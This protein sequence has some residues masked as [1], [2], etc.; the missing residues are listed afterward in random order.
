MTRLAASLSLSA[1][2]A[3]LLGAC[4]STPPAS[5][6]GAAPAAS[7][8]PFVAAPAPA[9]APAPSGA[10]PD[11]VAWVL[12]SAE[13]AAACHQA[14][15]LASRRIDEIAAGRPPG[16]WA[17]ALDVDETV[18]SN[19]D[20]EVDNETRGGAFDEGAW[21]RWVAKRSAPAL[22]GAVAFLEKVR[23]MGGRIALVTNR[24]EPM[25][26]DTAADLREQGVPFD[27]LLLRQSPDKGAKGPRWESVEQGTAAPGVPPTK[28]VLWVG[29]NI[30]D[31][32]GLDQT[33][34]AAGP[35]A[36]AAFGDRYIIVPNPMYGSW[37]PSSTPMAPT[38]PATAPV[39]APV[40]KP[41]PTPEPTP[42]N[43]NSGDDNSAPASEAGGGTLVHVDAVRV[44]LLKSLP[45]KLEATVVGNLSDG[46]TRLGDPAV[47][48][49]RRTFHVRLPATRDRGKMCTEALVPFER[50]FPVSISGLAS[51]TYTVE[52]GGK[53][54]TFT[55]EQDN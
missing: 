53:T 29:D 36:L 2:L 49:K 19:V 15:A 40:A 20:H 7:S 51:G 44:M 17:V 52:A 28:I 47:E 8:S 31:F 33:L 48:R 22:P 16:T 54:A 43:D 42:S 38:P 34:R 1:I 41:T 5:T 37:K 27:L 55:L 32:P 24:D 18:L 23:R 39:P 9:A 46:C 3:V 30:K 4:A 11:D 21:Q 12:R 25:R 35:Q 50:T 6:T 10:L 13:Y 14:F 45:A 26:E